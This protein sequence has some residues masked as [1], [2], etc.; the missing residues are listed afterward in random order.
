MGINELHEAASALY[1]RH[2]Y[3]PAVVENF[4]GDEVFGADRL[5]PMKER[6]QTSVKKVQKPSTQAKVAVGNAGGP[7]GGRT[8]KRFKA[9]GQW[10]HQE[11]VGGSYLPPG[12]EK[13][14][15]PVGGPGGKL[16]ANTIQCFSCKE[17]RH[18]AKDCPNK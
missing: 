16:G 2:I 13:S 9:N 14:D 18:Y 4:L 3:N 17:A 11:P 1:I 10:K 15:R 12:Y 8:A 5:A 6:M 7:F